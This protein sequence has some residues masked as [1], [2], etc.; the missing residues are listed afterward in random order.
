MVLVQHVCPQEGGD[1]DPAVSP[2]GLQVRIETVLGPVDWEEAVDEVSL[3][4]GQAVFGGEQVFDALLDLVPAETGPQQD[5]DEHRCGGEE[6]RVAGNE[7][8]ESGERRSQPS[9][10]DLPQHSSAEAAQEGEARTMESE[11]L[12]KPRQNHRGAQAGGSFPSGLKLTR[13]AT[14]PSSLPP[15]RCALGAA[16][17]FCLPP[18]CR[19][20]FPGAS[21]SDFKQQQRLS[22][23]GRRGEKERNH[24]LIDGNT[25]SFLCF[26]LWSLLPPPRQTKWV[27]FF[28]LSRSGMRGVGIGGVCVCGGGEHTC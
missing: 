9:V 21:L 25:Y 26:F 7:V 16:N 28:F 13:Q 18:G 2:R 4:L 8:A 19:G 15:P 17:A 5:G 20:E 12:P 3:D 14:L 10:Q 6:D 23:E 22:R 24:D 11:A 27:G 1:D